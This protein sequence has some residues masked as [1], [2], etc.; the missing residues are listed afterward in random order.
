MNSVEIR[1]ENTTDRAILSANAAFVTERI[2]YNCE[3]VLNLNSS[4]C[5]VFLAFFAAYTS[6]RAFRACDSA[7]FFIVAGNEN[8]FL[9]GHK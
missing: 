9:V 6:V 1:N 8:V 4:R 3:I 2:I 7:F 5:T